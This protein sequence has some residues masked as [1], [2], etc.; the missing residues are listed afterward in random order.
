[1]TIWRRGLPIVYLDAGDKPTL[2]DL[3]ERCREKLASLRLLLHPRK[4]RVSP[5]SEG[6]PFLGFRVW[7]THRRL[8]PSSVKRARRRLSQLETIA[9]AV[10]CIRA[11]IAHAEHGDTYG[12]RR[13]LLGPVVIARTDARV[14]ELILERLRSRQR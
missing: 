1:M 14:V 4:T 9:E 5:V 13:T 8:L 7:P 11:W 3:E 12:L 2:H 10:P 6:I